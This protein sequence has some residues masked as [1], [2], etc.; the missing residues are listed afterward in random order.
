MKTDKQVQQDVMAE[1]GWEPS[2]NSAQVGVEVSD[3]VVTL[4]GHV[5]SYA[6]KFAAERAAQRVLGVKAIAMEMDVKLPGTS[7]RTDSDIAR[8]TQN[9][10][11]WTAYLPPDRV[12]VKVENGWI[13]LSGEV[14]WDFQ[15]RAA[16]DAVRPLLGV[17]GVNDQITI[18]PKVS[19]TLVKS[20]IEAAL[21][22]RARNDAQNIFVAVQGSAVTLTGMV[23]SWSERDLAKSSAWATPGVHSVV[24]NMSITI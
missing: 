15:R 10:L 6:E 14:E 19:S 16:V 11:E 7:K 13:T 9:V 17:V 8:S 3:G 12:R 22:R 2:I 18:K 21:K 24:D 4:A 23:E 1:L 5:D 20:E